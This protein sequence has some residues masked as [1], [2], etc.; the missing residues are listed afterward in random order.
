M[1]RTQCNYKF[2]LCKF[3]LYNTMLSTLVTVLY[4][5]SLDLMHLV[6]EFVLFYQPLPIPNSLALA[7]Q[8][9]TLFMI[10]I[11]FY[12]YFS[13]HS[14]AHRNTSQPPLKLIWGHAQAPANELEMEV[15]CVISSLRQLRTHVNSHSSPASVSLEVLCSG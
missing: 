14:W 1:V 4:I 5:R 6:N 2:S 11:F 12:N 9:S 3:Q 10:S 15:M 8:F 13:S 7:T